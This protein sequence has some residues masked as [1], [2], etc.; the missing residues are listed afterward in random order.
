M[1]I[2]ETESGGWEGKNLKKIAQEIAE[3]ETESEWGYF[4]D[5]IAIY[6]HGEKGD[7]ELSRNKV[8]LFEV[9]GQE[10]F[11]HEKQSI[12]EDKDYRKECGQLIYDRF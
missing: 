3:M 12:L 1:W 2:V 6:Y 5:V 8:D 10:M 4:P 11:M 7:I 9:Y